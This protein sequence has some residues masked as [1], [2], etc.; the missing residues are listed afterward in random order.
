MTANRGLFVRNNGGVGTT[1]IEGRLALAGLVFE[2]A[3]G[4]PRSGLLDQKAATVVSGAANMSYNVAPI[5]PVVHRA[6]GEGVY[7]FTLTGTTNVPT[8]AA[9]G[10][11]SR[12]DLIYVK[13]NDLDKGD[14]DNAAIV[15]V[16]KGTPGVSPTKP[17]ADLPA[18]ALVLAEA[19]VNAGA[20][21]TNGAGVTIT[22]VWRYTAL[23]GAALP[24]RNKA[25]RDEITGPAKGMAIVR[26]D[27]DDWLQEY[28]GTAWTFVGWRKGTATAT[29]Y[30]SA[31]AG[32]RQIALINETKPYA[33]LLNIEGRLSVLC[34]AIASGVS[35][36]NVAVSAATGQVTSAQGKAR[37]A[38]TSGYSN[39]VQTK[40]VAARDVQVGAGGDAMVRLWIEVVNGAVSLTPTA[41][42]IHSDLWYEYKPQ[43]D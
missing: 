18:G 1:P 33:R 26:L 39:V 43:D 21:G 23:R 40:T 41:P 42:P 36:I 32:S 24:I 17:Y 6:T 2:N 25:E 29:W 4:I 31:G 15:A 3:P 19:Q 8:D 10:T 38:W 14:A 16:Q 12:W 37:M 27:C 9:P 13:Q 7:I 30:T 20:S 22:Q 35:E 5:T 28:N 34:P 11:G